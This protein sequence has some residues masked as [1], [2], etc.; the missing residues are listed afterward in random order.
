MCVLDKSSTEHV[1]T[2]D[3]FYADVEED[4]VIHSQ[5]CN[6]YEVQSNE[7]SKVIKFKSITQ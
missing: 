3:V 4:N 2:M 7:T 6:V 5:R 1:K